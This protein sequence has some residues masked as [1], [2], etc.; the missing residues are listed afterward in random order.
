MIVDFIIVPIIKSLKDV[1]ETI[2]GEKIT[3]VGLI[4]IWLELL[5]EQHTKN[6]TY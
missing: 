3:T 2:D 4:N 6:F 5:E 1:T